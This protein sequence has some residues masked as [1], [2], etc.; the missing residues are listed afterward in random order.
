M[1]FLNL[2]IKDTVYTMSRDGA[3]FTWKA[4]TDQDMETDEDDNT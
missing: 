1:P 2:E 4:E 3:V